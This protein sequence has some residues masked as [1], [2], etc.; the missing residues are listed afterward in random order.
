MTNATNQGIVPSSV[1]SPHPTTCN[2]Q[3]FDPAKPYLLV[4]LKNHTV[5]PF[6]DL[7]CGYD[8]TCE[9][10]ISTVSLHDQLGCFVAAERHIKTLQ[11]LG[12]PVIK[13]GETV[14]FPMS[15]DDIHHNLGHAH[16]GALTVHSFFEP[17]SLHNRMD[18]STNTICGDGTWD[19]FNH[20]SGAYIP[21]PLALKCA[22]AGD[23]TVNLESRNSGIQQDSQNGGLAGKHNIMLSVASHNITS[24]CFED[25]VGGDTIADGIKVHHAEAT[26][27]CSPLLIGKQHIRPGFTEMIREM[28][29]PSLS[30]SAKLLDN[31]ESK[32]SASVFGQYDK[33]LEKDIRS[34]AAQQLTPGVQTG[35][36]S[37][38]AADLS[39]ISMKNLSANLQLQYCSSAM[40]GMQQPYPIAAPTLIVG[41]TIGTNASE[42]DSLYGDKFATCSY[43]LR[44]HFDLEVG[45]DI[46]PFI[47]M[48]AMTHG[49]FLKQISTKRA[50]AICMPFV[51]PKS[52]FL[53]C[54][55]QTCICHNNEKNSSVIRSPETVDVTGAG[56]ISKLSQKLA[57]MDVGVSQ[58]AALMTSN[59]MPRTGLVKQPQ[60]GAPHMFEPRN[61]PAKGPVV[62]TA[63][64]FTG[65]CEC[66]TCVDTMK[67]IKI[68]QIITAATHSYQRCDNYCADITPTSMTPDGV[69]G[70]QSTESM[71]PFL[72]FANCVNARNVACEGGQSMESRISMGMDDCENAGFQTMAILETLQHCQTFISDNYF[73]RPREFASGSSGVQGVSEKPTTNRISD[74]EVIKRMKLD[75]MSMAEQMESFLICETLGE[76]LKSNLAFFVT[77]SPSQANDSKST[78]SF[79]S[80]EGASSTTGSMHTELE[81]MVSTIPTMNMVSS[82]SSTEGE[83]LRVFG[84]KPSGRRMT[85]PSKTVGAEE[86]EHSGGLSGHCTCTLSVDRADGMSYVDITEG[87]SCVEYARA[88]RKISVSHRAMLTNGTPNKEEIGK[89]DSEITIDNE[90][91]VTYTALLTTHVANIGSQLGVDGADMRSRLVMG[92]DERVKNNIDSFYKGMISMGSLQCIQKVGNDAFRPGTSVKDLVN[93]KLFKTIPLSQAMK[94]DSHLLETMGKA[95]IAFIDVSTSTK[96]ENAKFSVN[97]KHLRESTATLRMG[98]RTQEKHILTKLGAIPN[99][100]ANF[101]DDYE[102]SKK[103]D[104]T[105]CVFSTTYSPHNDSP[106]GAALVMHNISAMAKCK[107]WT[108]LNVR[109]SDPIMMESGEIVAFWKLYGTGVDPYAI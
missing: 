61:A 28:S 53:P 80:A 32:L 22:M 8:A 68:G 21:T 97:C 34:Y 99:R 103:Y 15:V 36:D 96:E 77:G 48:M 69:V 50:A 11:G 30:Y 4:T 16:S 35:E 76:K 31:V 42:A 109:F 63:E 60:A 98:I 40:V 78:K 55:D 107:N 9:K 19:K 71:H 108:Y 62:C 14:A 104:N 83:G 95:D 73:H 29:G 79:V 6:S 66:K 59:S 43:A 12:Y 65:T 86:D 105:S 38:G 18:R 26:S 13:W 52:R 102:L 58:N 81:N 41:S 20:L 17:K 106:E 51:N 75:T 74:S 25:G 39:L 67:F 82:L 87:T 33:R 54:S 91:D 23:T 47:G 85:M 89:Y 27:D 94:G 101:P 49:L 72:S 7:E 57:N 100:V 93:Q 10:I 56:G 84:S 92:T 64:E 88:N 5:N 46:H 45:K 70:Y 2:G 24:I 90:C 44:Q 1:K 3:P 37:A